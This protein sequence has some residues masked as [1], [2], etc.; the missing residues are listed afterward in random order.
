MKE[1]DR[2]TLRACDIY[3]VTFHVSVCERERH[4]TMCMSVF[5]SLMG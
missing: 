2:E 5:E 3:E 4:V 1:K